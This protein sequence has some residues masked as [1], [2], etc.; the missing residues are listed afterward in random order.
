MLIMKKGALSLSIN[1]LVVIIISLV[2]LGAGITLL[3]KFIGG[4][5]DIKGQLDTKTD[6][7]LERL[8][9]SEGKRVVL[10]LHIANVER[11]TTHVFGIG[12][13]NLRETSEEFSLE[14][15]LSTPLDQSNNE[16]PLSMLDPHPNT[17][18]LYT[19]KF[20]VPAGDYEKQAILI[21][22]PKDAI[23][24]RYIFNAKIFDK[25][26]VQYGNTQKFTVILI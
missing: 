16:I 11:G 1:T 3:Y 17:W 19:Q 20:S 5:E 24:G 13:L 8:L 25:N 21:K 18:A 15:S 7:E 10:P 14:V 6:Q 22:V 4:A 23:K 26:G 2:I 12:V 9:I